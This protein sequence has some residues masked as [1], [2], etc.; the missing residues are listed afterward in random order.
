MEKK[1][2]PFCSVSLELSYKMFFRKICSGYNFKRKQSWQK[3]D[4]FNSMK[5]F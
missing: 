5:L 4:L 3:N 1:L 2:S